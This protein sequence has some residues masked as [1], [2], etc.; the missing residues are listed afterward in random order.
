MMHKIV[1]LL[2]VDPCGLIAEYKVSAE[3]PA[4]IFMVS[5]EMQA[6]GSFESLVSIYQITRSDLKKAVGLI[7]PFSAFRLS[8]LVF[9]YLLSF[10]VFFSVCQSSRL[11]ILSSIFMYIYF[12]VSFLHN[13]TRSVHP[14]S[15]RNLT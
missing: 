3:H 5:L 1:I 6:A 15:I 12:T 7:L 11:E 10:V 9:L 2:I 4:S 14:S 8:K 13:I